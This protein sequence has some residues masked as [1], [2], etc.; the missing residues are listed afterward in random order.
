VP[1]LS[2]DDLKRQ[3]QNVGSGDSPLIS[4]MRLFPGIR[5]GNRA[6]DVSPVTGRIGPFRWAAPPGRWSPLKLELPFPEGGDPFPRHQSSQNPR[7][8][9]STTY[10]S[11]GRAESLPMISHR[12]T[13]RRGASPA[14][15]ES[16]R[17]K[18]ERKP[19]PAPTPFPATVVIVLAGCRNFFRMRLARF[20]KYMSL[21][22]AESPP[23]IIVQLARRRQAAIP[24]GH[25]PL[26]TPQLSKSGDCRDYAVPE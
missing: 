19:A 9:P 12:E 16:Q 1:N 4:R 7:I 6:P 15:P 20:P 24:S 11:A 13:L 8:P 10:R 5:R 23:L 2:I 21:G 22:R 18:M 14:E 3:P 26:R 17:R 25:T